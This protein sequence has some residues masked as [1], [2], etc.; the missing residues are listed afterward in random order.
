MSQVIRVNQMEVIP[1]FRYT[2][3]R[4][5]LIVTDKSAIIKGDISEMREGVRQIFKKGLQV[6]VLQEG[7]IIYH[8]M[9]TKY[10]M[11]LFFERMEEINLYTKLENIS[12]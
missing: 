6:V 5:S 4:Y 11:R 10:E 8:D 1:D 12:L 7:E 2:V 9:T 3:G